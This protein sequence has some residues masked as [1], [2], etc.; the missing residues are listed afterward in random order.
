MSIFTT[1][2]F[3]LCAY[4]ATSMGAHNQTF[5]MIGNIDNGVCDPFVFFSDSHGQKMVMGGH[6]Y[7][8]DITD[9]GATLFFDGKIFHSKDSI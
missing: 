5:M 9:S 4:L 1:I 2:A 6:E 3:G 8:V 7:G